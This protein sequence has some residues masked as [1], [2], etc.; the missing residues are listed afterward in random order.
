MECSSI[1]VIRRRTR[2][3][4]RGPCVPDWHSSKQS[5]NCLAQSGCKSVLAPLQVWSWLAISSD[6]AQRRRRRS[7]SRRRTWQR[8]CRPWR[9]LAP[10]PS[11]R[12]RIVCWAVCL[13]TA[14]SAE[15]RQRASPIGCKHTRWCV[16]AWWRA[17]SRR[18]ARRPRRWSAA[19]RRLICSCD[20]GSRPSIAQ[21]Q[22]AAS[23]LREDTAE[24]RLAKLEAVLA[25]GTND[26]G[27]A[28]PLLAD[29]LSIPTG[30]RYPP[31]NL[32]PQK[33]KEKTV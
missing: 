17:G 4:P 14:I 30:D 25:Q 29:L 10:S 24:Q 12:P 8:V 23:F 28:V 21:L 27:E 19:T 2:M 32:T 6:R 7:L 1:S 26:L 22:R 11:I 20:G 3:M 13:S 18:C 9:C 33:R 15:S 31:L 5:P 16:R